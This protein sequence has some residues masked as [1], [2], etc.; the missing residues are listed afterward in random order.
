M[1]RRDFLQRVGV[2]SLAAGSIP[3]LS[4]PALAHLSSDRANERHFRFVCLSLAGGTEAVVMEGSGI[5]T[6]TEAHQANGSFLHFTWPPPSTLLGHGTWKKKRGGDFSYEKGFGNLE[7]IEASIVTMDI[8]MIPGEDTGAD[9]FTATLQVAC[10]V[11]PF[12]LLTGLDEGIILTLPD[13]TTFEPAVPGIGLTF[14]ST[15]H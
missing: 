3:L 4:Q 5:F 14:I 11:G 12:G 8:R 7:V 2:G 6:N 13:G 10:N 1:N 9:P 15:K